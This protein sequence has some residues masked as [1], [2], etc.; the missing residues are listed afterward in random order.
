MNK[1]CITITTCEPRLELVKK[2]LAMFREQTNIPIFLFVNGNYI[3]PHSENYRKAILEQCLKYDEIYPSFY[4]KFRGLSKIWNDQICHSGHEDILMTNDDI[5]ILPGF[6]DEFEKAYF[7]M[8][9]RTCLKI[10]SCWSTVFLNKSWMDG[11][12]YFDEHH[13]L[14]IGFEDTE[15]VSRNGDA[16]VFN[17]DKHINLSGQTS[18]R[19]AG[20]K[21]PSDNCPNYNN[22]NHVWWHTHTPTPGTNFRP[23]EH[24]YDENY[25]IFWTK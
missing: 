19:D 8:N 7:S 16:P 24:Y 1:Y 25:G 5:T 10:N 23:F 20:A 4:G 11:R 18:L 22:W 3:P 9:P 14:G 12:G 6:V 15:F 21:T 13:Y 17:T 2:T